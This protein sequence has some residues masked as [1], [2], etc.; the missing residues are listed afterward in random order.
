MW[1]LPGGSA[2][3][4]PVFRFKRKTNLALA[5]GSWP[6]PTKN[7]SRGWFSLCMAA[8]GGKF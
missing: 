1:D 6:N 7:D 3:K 5:A 8:S 2:F 4:N